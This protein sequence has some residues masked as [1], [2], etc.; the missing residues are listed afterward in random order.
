MIQIYWPHIVFVISV[1]AGAAAAIHAAMTKNDV[2]AAFGWV[3]VILMSPL[4]GPLFYLVAGINRVRRD[5]ISQQ[6]ERALKHYFNTEAPTVADVAPYSGTPF[7]S[8]IILGD[9]VTR[10]TFTA[11][12][13]DRK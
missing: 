7:A 9:Q 8:L 2:R 4:F 5:Q 11:R 1:V 12:N 10:F 3:G 6:R 13:T